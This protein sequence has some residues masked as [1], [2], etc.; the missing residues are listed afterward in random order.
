MPSKQDL[1]LLFEALVAVTFGLDRQVCE[2][3]AAVRAL[4]RSDVNK[5]SAERGN[6]NKSREWSHCFAFPW[7]PV[8]C[9]SS[10]VSNNNGAF[11]GGRQC[12]ATPQ[13]FLQLSLFSEVPGFLPAHLPTAAVIVALAEVTFFAAITLAAASV[14][15]PVT[16]LAVT[17]T[18]PADSAGTGAAMCGATGAPT[19][20][21]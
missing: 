3:A 6:S 14:V 8:K 11:Q 16:A 5:Q 7:L 12:C 1:A 21:L 19:M 9:Y 18:A 15:L 2:T 10:I 20:G 13:L 17:V 4:P